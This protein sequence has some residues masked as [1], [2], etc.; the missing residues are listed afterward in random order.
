MTQI[1]IKRG[2]PIGLRVVVFALAFLFSFPGIYLIWRN[3]TEDSDPISLIGTERILSPLW[4]SVSLALAVSA[5]AGTLLGSCHGPLNPPPSVT[6]V[7]GF[8]KSASL[9]MMFFIFAGIRQGFKEIS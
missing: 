8:V 5:S 1:E 7:T 4:R 9:L 2:A 3:L 6:R